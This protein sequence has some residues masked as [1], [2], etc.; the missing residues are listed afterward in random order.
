[1]TLRASTTT[2]ESYRL[3]R[4]P[5]NEW[6]TEQN[7]LDTIMGRFTPTPEMLLGRAFGQILETPERYQVPHGYQC[8]GY[9]FSDADLAPAFAL[10]NYEHGVFECKG[11]KDY[12]D[13]TVVAKV[14]QIVGA[15]IHEHKTTQSTFSAEK[16]LESC[17]W[18][19]YA[20]V[21][22]AAAV[23]Y[24]V[25]LLDDHG[26]GVVEVRGIESLALYP[27]PRL[28][29]DCAALAAEFREYI[30]SKSLDGL[31]AQRQREAA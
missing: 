5:Q 8:E 13:L 14:D 3:Y 26:N 15:H 11:T 24:H 28:H 27:Y 25:F 9:T 16:Y 7:L 6:A 22:E 21:Y 29:D 2:L 4:D 23:T 12:G 20:D 17:Q 1:M 18:R 30:R 31:L 19:Y 10:M